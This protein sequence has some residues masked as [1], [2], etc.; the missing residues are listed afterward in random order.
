MKVWRYQV[1]ES[2]L[3]DA[4]VDAVYALATDPQMVP[5]YASEVARIEVVKKLNE[6]LV[7]V[8]SYLKI[9]GI[10]RGFLYQYH[11]RPPSHYSGV[12]QH[13]RLLRGYFNLR[14]TACERG[15]TV[16]HTEG[17]LSRIPLLAWLSGFLYFRIIAR[18]GMAEELRKL[19]SLVE[20]DVV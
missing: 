8:M 11:Y 16:S 4:P 7:M 14:F 2:V 18:G 3:I 19:K 6:H 10:T 15:T 5:S 9:A 12:Q 1:S 13:G 17:V 20:G